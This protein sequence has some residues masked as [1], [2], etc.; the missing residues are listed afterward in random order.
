MSRNTVGQPGAASPFICAGAD[1]HKNDTANKA[2]Q[3]NTFLELR[4]ISLL[5]F[6]WTAGKRQAFAK[7]HPALCRLK[8]ASRCS[9]RELQSHLSNPRR[10]RTC[11]LTEVAAQDIAGH[12]VELGVIKHVEVFRP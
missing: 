12:A 4:F 5:Q 7:S 6:F 1:P 11:N 8:K 9:K 2:T 10:T 3:G